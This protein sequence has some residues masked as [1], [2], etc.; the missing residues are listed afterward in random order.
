[1]P[2]NERLI[3]AREQRG[4]SQSKAADKIGISRVHYAR[5]ESRLVQPHGTTIG[6]ICDAFNMSAE[7]LGLREFASTTS[8]TGLI[9]VQQSTL[10]PPVVTNG[11]DID[12]FHVSMKG[13]VLAQ[14]QMGWTS[15]ELLAQVHAEMRRLTAMLHSRRDIMK[16]GLVLQSRLCKIRAGEAAPQ[17]KS[18]KNGYAMSIRFG[19]HLTSKMGL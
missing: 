13:L 15:D 5:L 1:V 10:Q 12:I 2:R 8:R 9:I 19:S 11:T 4:W 14:Q 6:M 3:Q 16:Q 17:A 7:A 18:P